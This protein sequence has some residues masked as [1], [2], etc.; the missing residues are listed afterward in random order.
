MNFIDYWVELRSFERVFGAVME[1]LGRVVSLG[2]DPIISPALMS[3]LFIKIY[4]YL[5]SILLILG[6]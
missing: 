4:I 1:D 5:L 3:K 2:E 6:G